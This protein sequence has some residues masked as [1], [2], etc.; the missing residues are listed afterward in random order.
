[1]TGKTIHVPTTVWTSAIKAGLL[2]LVCLLVGFIISFFSPR[3][4]LIMEP[5]ERLEFWIYLSVI[6]GIGIFATDFILEKLPAKWP[7]I[8]NAFAQTAGGTI[9]VL[10]P[11]YAYYHPEDLPSVGTT[12]LFVWFVMILIVAMATVLWGLKSSMPIAEGAP[13][14]SLENN[15]N[16]PAKILERLP[17]HLQ[18]SELYALSAEDHYVR[19]YTSKGEDLILMR[20][21]D[22]V[23]E[24]GSFEG[25]QVHRSWWVAKDAVKKITTKGRTAEIALSNDVIAPVSRNSLKTLREAGWV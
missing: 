17:V 1:M 24:T 12:V 2:F 9:A 20:L 19:V 4:T 14:A 18:S 15:L 16:N 10:I 21:S 25:L 11:L 6:G 5:L 22:A 3:V 7:G 8:V 13:A 23:T